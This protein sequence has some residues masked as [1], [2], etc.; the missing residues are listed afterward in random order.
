MYCVMAGWRVQN[1]SDFGFPVLLENLEVL[2]QE[3]KFFLFRSVGKQ[4]EGYIFLFSMVSVFTEHYNLIKYSVC[5]DTG[6]G[7]CMNKTSVFGEKLQGNTSISLI[8]F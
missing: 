5:G 7:S 8:S 1:I 2:L 6:R 4:T 3:A